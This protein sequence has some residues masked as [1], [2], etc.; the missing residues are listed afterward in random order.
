MK[1]FS[2]QFAVPDAARPTPQ[3]G[4]LVPPQAKPEALAAV[5]APAP[6]ERGAYV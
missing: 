6:E 4:R 1:P 2:Q 3:A 5:L